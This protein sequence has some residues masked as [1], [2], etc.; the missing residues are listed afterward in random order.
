MVAMENFL[1]AVNALPDGYQIMIDHETQLHVSLYRRAPPGGWPEPWVH[2]FERHGPRCIA[3]V[4]ADDMAALANLALM[5][6][7][8]ER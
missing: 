7:Q 3:S 6:V 8:K 5:M 4:N 2:P 1:R